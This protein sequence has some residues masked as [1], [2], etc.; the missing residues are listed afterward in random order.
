V[1][2]KRFEHQE[3]LFPEHGEPPLAGECDEDGAAVAALRTMTNL[4]L[5]E[6]ERTPTVHLDVA[7]ER[8]TIII[9]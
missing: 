5:G 6:I 9:E 4:T 8:F 1:A 2:S 3:E 7:G